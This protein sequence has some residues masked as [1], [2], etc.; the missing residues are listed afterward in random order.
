[1][2]SSQVSG[3]RKPPVVWHSAMRS[4]RSGASSARCIAVIP[5][6]ETPQT[7]ARSIPSA[8]SR[9]STSAAR[10]VIVYGP[11]GTSERPWPR[12]S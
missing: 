6:S 2:R 8:S 4:R 3:S 11:S 7:E 10:S 5:P 1:M 9:S 12:V